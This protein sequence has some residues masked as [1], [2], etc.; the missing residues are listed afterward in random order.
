MKVF[1]LFTLDFICGLGSRGCSK[2]LSAMMD[3]KGTAGKPLYL[4]LNGLLACIFFWFSS[5]FQI[6]VN[7]TNLGYGAAYTFLVI[8]ALTV[9]LYIYCYFSVA[10]VCVVTSAGSLILS[11]LCGFLFWHEEVTPAVLLRI[12]LM[13]AAI[14]LVYFSNKKEEKPIAEATPIKKPV[15][16]GVLIIVIQLVNTVL[17]T[18]VSKLYAATPVAH[19]S[20]SMFFLVNV[21]LILFAGGWLAVLF[22]RDKVTTVREIRH[23]R[24]RVMG[25]ILG[26]CVCSNTSSLVSVALLQLVAVSVCS[27]ISSALGIL[28]GVLISLLRGE[29]LNAF[30]Y[31]A[32][33]VCLV[34]IVLPG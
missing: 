6:A 30:L 17:V 26:N 3:G 22:M 28:C 7:A 18:V 13:V 15:N 1:L 32:V 2:E 8:V 19:Q 33:A 12:C 14:A 20:S 9:A 21:F 31:G 25:A 10:V 27:P 5:R 16:R 23:F 11:S 29:K 4:I 24:P 34:A